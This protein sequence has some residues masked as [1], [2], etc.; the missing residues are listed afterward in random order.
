MEI[1]IKNENDVIIID[2]EHLNGYEHINFTILKD[3]EYTTTE[4]L[5]LDT[6]LS[7][8]ESFK[9]QRD[10]DWIREEHYNKI[11]E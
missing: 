11:G 9:K 1:K 8:L 3:G 6:L 5:Y 4:C 7:A 10:L 2:D